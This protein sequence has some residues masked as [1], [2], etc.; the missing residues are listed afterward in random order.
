[1]PVPPPQSFMGGMGNMPMQPPGGPGMGGQMPYGNGRNNFGS[2]GFANG[3]V[4]TT[5]QVSYFS[6]TQVATV[7]CDVYLNLGNFVSF[8]EIFR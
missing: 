4:A 7:Q 2:A 3:G 8:R 5:Q 1:M 6:V